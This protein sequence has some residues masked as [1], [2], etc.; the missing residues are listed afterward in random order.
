MNAQGPMR[1]PVGFQQADPQQAH[2][3]EFGERQ[4][5]I[6]IGRKGDADLK[7]FSRTQICSGAGQHRAQLLR[8]RCTLLMKIA[9]IGLKEWSAKTLGGKF[10]NQRRRGQSK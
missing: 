8:R 10:L 4:E 3:A 5:H 7:R 2:G 6:L 1:Y 9:A